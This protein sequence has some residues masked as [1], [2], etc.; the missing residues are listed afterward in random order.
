MAPRMNSRETLTHARRSPT[1]VSRPSSVKAV[2]TTVEVA[3]S[4]SEMTAVSWLF[5][6]R[7]SNSYAATSSCGSKIGCLATK[8]SADTL[9][10]P[11][12]ALSTGQSSDL[13]AL[14]A[15]QRHD[16]DDRGREDERR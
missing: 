14:S 9:V 4:L 11:S 3:S 7:N 5:A 2:M 1:T 15:Q 8:T 10:L 12:S 13:M 16:P 6:P